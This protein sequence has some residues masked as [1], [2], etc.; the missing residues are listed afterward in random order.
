MNGSRREFLTASALAAGAALG[1]GGLPRLSWARREVGAGK[2]MLIL[3]GTG[4]L[5]P[6]VVEEAK[7]AGWHVTTF[8]RGRTNADLFEDDPAVEGLIGNRDGDLKSLEGKT[9]DAVVDTSGYVPRIVR[10]SATLLKDSV[11][12]YVFI[13][14]ISAFADFDKVGIDESYPV[15]KME[16]ETVES[17]GENFQNY[18]PLKALCEQAAEAAIPGRVTNIRPGYIVGPRDSS[19]RFNYWPV[20]VKRGGEMIAPGDPSDPV[21]IIDV[22]DLAAWIVHC[23]DQKVV[24]VFNATGPDRKMSIAEMIEACKQGTGGDPKL[25]WIDAD[26]LQEHGA[27]LPI[28]APPRGPYTGFAQVDCRRAIAAGLRF[29]P[30]SQTARDTLEWYNALPEDARQRRLAAMPPEKEAEIL[31]AWKEAHPGG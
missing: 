6:H 23:C 11:G 2:R 21:Q 15:G 10:D 29:R 24:G 20:R 18:G 31:A 25:V 12:Q 13:S 7:K 16:D 4:F 1:F 19:G 14:S 3:G 28:W 26:F 9:W 27:G 8:T 22:R 30:A 17:M 5:G